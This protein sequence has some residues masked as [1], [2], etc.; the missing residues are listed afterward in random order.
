MGLVLKYV[1]TTAAGTL[2][3]RRKVPKALKSAFGFTEFKRKL[4]DNPR[5]ALLVYPRVNAEYERL[6]LVARQVPQTREVVKTALELHAEAEQRLRKLPDN[7]TED[8]REH[9]ADGLVAGYPRDPETGDPVG[10]PEPERLFVNGLRNGTV[11]PKP[12]PTFEDAKRLYLKDRV[13]G[14]SNEAARRSRVERVHGFVTKAIGENVALRNI[15]RAGARE[16]RDHMLSD[17]RLT[18]ATAKRYVNDIR[19]IVSLGIREY[20][21]DVVNPFAN[22]EI[23]L[24]TI[25]RHERKPFTEVQVREVQEQLN[26]HASDD[27]KLIFRMLSGTGCRLAE[28]TG[29]LVTDVYLE[30]KHPYVNLVFHPHRRL[31]TNASIRRV[32]LIGDALAAAKASVKAAGKSATLFPSYGRERGGDNASAALMRHV[33][34]VTTDAKVTVHSARHLMEDRMIRA[35]VDEYDRNLV[36][37]HT[38]RGQGDRYGSDEARLEATTRALNLTFDHLA[39]RTRRGRRNR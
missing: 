36:L 8:V 19:A 28:I 3:Y 18:P 17:L 34:E 33:R 11:G 15:G 20:E 7:L 21:L 26:K 29:L 1:Q 5:Q 6:L 38:R 39:G 9:W 13:S 22:L 14:E 16:V 35:G 2:H 24:D 10:V 31:K 37:G 27:L 25:A 30:D 32:P 4:G 23:K 12:E